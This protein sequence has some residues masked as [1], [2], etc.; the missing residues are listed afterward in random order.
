M[1]A[2][3]SALPAALELVRIAFVS[4]RRLPAELS[5]ALELVRVVPGRRLPAELSAAL[6]LRRLRAELSAALEL[7]R[8]ACVSVALPVAL[9]RAIFFS[10]G[11]IIG[12]TGGSGSQ[13][14]L[15]PSLSCLVAS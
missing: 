10:I 11:C 8:I 1:P 3:L 12:C 14:Q 2:E 13:C 4:W 7:V 9:R 6:E 15:P 5:A